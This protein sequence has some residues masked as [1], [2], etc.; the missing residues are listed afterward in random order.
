VIEETLPITEFIG[1]TSMTPQVKPNSWSCLPT[2]FA[3]ASGYTLDR[4]LDIIGHDG[5]KIVCPELKDPARRRG[6]HVQECIL[7]VMH[8]G[9]AA[10]PVERLPIIQ[11]ANEH[12]FVPVFY[13]L[14]GREA[15]DRIFENHL[16]GNYRVVVIGRT[17]AGYDH[18]MACERGL[19]Y[20]PDDGSRT[21]YSK[22]TCEDLGFRPHTL[23]ILTTKG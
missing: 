19:L 16:F 22:R 5:S 15:N 23:W 9:Y 6:F 21:P 20:N 7:A 14:A 4:L 11:T 8:L 18:A 3:M 1:M 12:T 10:T 13:R 17:R 2:A